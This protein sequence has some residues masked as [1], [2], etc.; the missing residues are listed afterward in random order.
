M[1]RILEVIILNISE[2]YLKYLL[3]PL[4]ELID[5]LISEEK[6][7]YLIN[8]FIFVVFYFFY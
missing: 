4:Y 6:D 7:F 3:Y 2:N 5:H 1:I 8:C